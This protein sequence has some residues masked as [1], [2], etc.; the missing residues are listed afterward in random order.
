MDASQLEQGLLELENLLDRAIVLGSEIWFETF[1]FLLERLIAI[2]RLL[3]GRIVGLLRRVLPV[4][5]G[6]A[7]LA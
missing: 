6:A 5:D 3:S 4:A 2:L 7:A 1:A